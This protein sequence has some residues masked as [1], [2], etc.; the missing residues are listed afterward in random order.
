MNPKEEPCPDSALCLAG[1]GDV[2]TLGLPGTGTTG[3]ADSEVSL[4]LLF[5]FSLIGL[6]TAVGVLRV[7]PADAR[8]EPGTGDVGVAA[9]DVAEADVVWSIVG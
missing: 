7:A 8:L 9:G 5:I 4:F 2:G 6:E 1:G 3:T